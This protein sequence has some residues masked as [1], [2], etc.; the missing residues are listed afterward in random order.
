MATGS[1]RKSVPLEVHATITDRPDELKAAVASAFSGG[2]TLLDAQ[3]LDKEGRAR[4]T[5]PAGNETQAVRAVLGPEIETDALNVGEA[6]RRGG[7]DPTSRCVP[8]SR[9]VT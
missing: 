2:R 7:V 1:T 9:L 3:P 6:L 5:I 8:A 4:L